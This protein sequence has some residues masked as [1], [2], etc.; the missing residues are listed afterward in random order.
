MN[1]ESCASCLTSLPGLLGSLWFSLC[2]NF[3]KYT[4]PEDGLWIA[5][6]F[7]VG[8]LVIFGLYFLFLP[9]STRFYALL[10]CLCQLYLSE[11]LESSEVG[12][13]QLTEGQAWHGDKSLGSVNPDSVLGLSQS[14]AGPWLSDLH[15]SDAE[16]RSNLPKWPWWST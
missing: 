13:I 1:R 12:K 10:V 7:W 16:W 8:L 4:G 9:T 11:L 15:L 14:C 5:A 2:L 3:I 6:Q